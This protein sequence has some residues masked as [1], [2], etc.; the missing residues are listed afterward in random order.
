MNVHRLQQLLCTFATKRLAVV[1]DV[2]LDEFVWGKVCRVSPEAPVPVVEV[3]SE[4]H[5]PGGAANVAR[6][7]KPFCQSVYIF[8][9]IGRDS[10]GDC[11][12]RLLKNEGI[13]TGYLVKQKNFS[14]VVKTRIIALHQQIVRVDRENKGLSA[15]D[16]RI[17]SKQ[18]LK[19]FKRL[20]PSLDGIIFEDY[21]KGFL[22][23]ELKDR[24]CHMANGKGVIVAADPS[25]R[26]LLDWTGV[27]VIKPNRSEVFDF[28]GVPS[29]LVNVINPVEDK[30]LLQACGRLQ[31]RW[32][33]PQLLITLG[34]QGMFLIRPGFSTYHIPAHAKEVFD[35][36]G[37]GDTTI[38]MYTLALCAGATP[39]EAAE[40]SNHAASI[41]VGKLGTATLTTE[42]LKGSFE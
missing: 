1:G 31:A 33:L 16:T 41:V 15:A 37:A 26:N 38:A 13:L 8:G 3:Q 29:A 23:Q 39:E 40:I 22:N 20:L 35:V 9:L 21:G 28:A 19:M 30:Q 10:A 2:M 32:E 12:A 24:L 5:Y 4:S 14:T 6:N 18:V 36:S 42:E 25:S 27:T 17:I 11:L 7:L 34:E